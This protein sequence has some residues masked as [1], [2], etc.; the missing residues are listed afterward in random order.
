MA[1]SIVSL[2]P[3][4]TSLHIFCQFSS[5]SLSTLNSLI[6]RI[7]CVCLLESLS[8]QNFFVCCLFQSR[9][10]VRLVSSSYYLLYSI[11]VSFVSLSLPIYSSVSVR[12]VSLSP[13]VFCLYMSLPVVLS[14][15]ILYLGLFPPHVFIIFLFLPRHY[16]KR[17]KMA[18]SSCS[19]VRVHLQIWVDLFCLMGLW[20]FSHTVRV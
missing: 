8:N 10:S 3:L 9:I 13:P 16:Y 14:L 15:W 7:S 20:H 18:G 6:L 17:L 4:F 2:F 12:L 11:S 19:Q 5:L 1:S